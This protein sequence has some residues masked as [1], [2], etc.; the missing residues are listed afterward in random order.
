MTTYFSVWNQQILLFW[1]GSLPPEA[2]EP[3]Y[4]F[5]EDPNNVLKYWP[6]IDGHASWT[7]KLACFM[8]TLSAQNLKRIHAQFG[9]IPIK[10]G[11]RHITSLK[12]AHNEYLQQTKKLFLIKQGAYNDEQIHYKLPPL[13]PY[14]DIGTRILTFS[15]RSA[16]FADCGVG[17]TYMVLVSTQEKL[18]RG[19]VQPGKTL[20][21][22]KLN[23][24]F[25]GWAEDCKKFTDMSCSVLWTKS[26][27][28]KKEK[29]RDLL[30]EHADIYIIN[31]DGLRVFEKELAAMN[32][33]Q[34]VVDESTILKGFRGESKALK[35]GA[36]GKSLM[37][38][39][40]SATHRVIMSGTPAP[41]G[42]EDLW[43]QLKFLD[44]YGFT[45]EASKRDFN[46]AFMNEIRMGRGP[47]A[48]KKLVPKP[49]TTVIISNK[50]EN[51]SYRV[52]IR[53]H[54]KDLP[55]KTVIE[56]PVEMGADQLKHYNNMEKELATEITEGNYVT[57]D[58]KLTAIGKLRQITGGFLID[59]Q[60]D[61]HEIEHASKVDYMDS[62]LLEEIGLEHKT[63]IWAQ[64]R[65][66][67]EML[68]SRYKDY[69]AVTVYGGN[70]SHKN[71][72]NIERFINDPDIKLCILHPKSAAHGITFT[73][74]HY[75]IF[76][77]ISFSYEDDYQCVARIERASQK[78][79]MFVYYL[80][81]EDSIDHD[82]MSA[83][84]KKARNQTA[85]IDGT[86]GD[87]G[88]DV[89]DQFLGRVKEK[90]SKKS[91]KT[92]R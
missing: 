87:I 6:H 5:R 26:N 3:D 44:P 83:I 84:K 80:L 74:A 75:M 61:V 62:L 77:S 67:I 91:K 73:C 76:Y 59:E 21:C 14:Q 18:R 86:T 12:E 81:C 68:H 60:E 37:K 30:S 35:G 43:G 15:N 52:R 47:N 45:L 89:I 8:M 92:K 24:L 65:H 7:K 19:V 50:I 53:D 9:K 11:Y 39:S 69:G 10:A 22:G 55:P 2:T 38:V 20:I 48:P 33:Q 56:R 27:Y 66:E 32:F 85:L 90:Y 79:A 51:I 25:S 78:H 58:M 4:F 1:D 42:P 71:L 17:K 46:T 70:P 57:V 41:N 72:E 88:E 82:I 64:Y 16:L 34:V 13:A 28:K 31:H 40:H 54:L 23:T 63:V 36:F 29:I 49:D